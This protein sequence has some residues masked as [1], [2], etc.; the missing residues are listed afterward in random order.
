MQRHGYRAPSHAL[1]GLNQDARTRSCWPELYMELGA[2]WQQ[3]KMRTLPNGSRVAAR[4]NASI[5]RDRATQCPESSSS[6]VILYLT[7]DKS[8][9]VSAP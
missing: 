2:S 4:A 6:V 1:G 9:V 7:G 3:P 5:S 8:K